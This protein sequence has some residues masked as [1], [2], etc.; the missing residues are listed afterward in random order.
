MS[1]YENVFVV[2]K[3]DTSLKA[4]KIIFNIK[5]KVLNVEGN[6]KINRSKTFSA[7]ADK[8]VIDSDYS[9]FRIIG[10]TVSKV[11]N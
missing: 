9:R 7:E 11:Y 4:D 6:V 2:L 10:K 1:I 8:A 3:D 5:E